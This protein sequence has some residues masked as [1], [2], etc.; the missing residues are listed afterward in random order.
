M[1][2]GGAVMTSTLLPLLPL[3]SLRRLLARLCSHGPPGLLHSARPTVTPSKIS[4][5][6]GHS[7]TR[8]AGISPTPTF[9]IRARR[10]R[11]LRRRRRCRGLR[12]SSGSG[13][14]LLVLRR[15]A[16][17]RAARALQAHLQ[18]A[19]REQRPVQRA[20]PRVAAPVQAAAFAQSCHFRPRGARRGH[21]PSIPVR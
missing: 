15:D 12:L 10:I 6:R 21:Q 19:R 7:R 3:P 20:R 5:L 13:P 4:C 1:C 18:G 14:R 11:R 17:Q 9:R 2:S 16:E 8:A